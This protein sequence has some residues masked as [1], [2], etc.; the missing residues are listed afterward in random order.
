MTDD[1]E[2]AGLSGA[3]LNESVKF[4]YAQA[5]EVLKA[6]RERS[7]AEVT[8]TA[9]TPKATTH[10]RIKA[11]DVEGHV[12]AVLADPLVGTVEADVDV[13]NVK[14]GGKVVAVDL[15]SGVSDWDQS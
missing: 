5:G 10:G 4:L 6:R 8:A 1:L 9:Q 7:T 11:R 12:V 13:R 2:L 3:A 15:R 14:R